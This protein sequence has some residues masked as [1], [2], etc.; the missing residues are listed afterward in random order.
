[1]FLLG[2]IFFITVWTNKFIV[3]GSIF[4]YL[5]VFFPSDLT[6]RLKDFDGP[7]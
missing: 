4:T 6:T 5:S 1:M 3:C 7:L 2:A